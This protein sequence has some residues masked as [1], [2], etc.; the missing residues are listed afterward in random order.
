MDIKLLMQDF[1]NRLSLPY[2]KKSFQGGGM[3]TSELSLSGLAE[4]LVENGLIDCQSAQKALAESEADQNSFVA[5]VVEKKLLQAHDIA[6][7]AYQDYGLPLLDLS[8]YD[9]E[10]IPL[11]LV[12]EKL[13]TKHHAL[14]LFRRNHHL[15]VAIS[16]PNNVL[17]LTEIKF[18]TGLQTKAVLVE[19]DKLEKFIENVL[20]AQAGAALGDLSDSSLDNLDISSDDDDN[21]EESS[22]GDDAPIVRFVH[23]ILLDAI[24]KGASDIHFEPYEKI[25][26]VRYRID[27]VLHENAT[28]PVKLANRIVSRLKVMSRLDISERRIPQ[29]GRFK[30][31]LSHKRAIDFRVSTCP[32]VNGEKVV[33]RILDPS[34]AKIGIDGLGF[35][36]DQKATFLEA[37]EQPQGMIL[38]TGPTGSGKTVTLYTA[39][40]LLNTREKNISTAEDPVEIHVPGINQVNINSKTGLDFSS[41]LRSFLRQDPDII[42]VGEMRDLETAEIGVKAA[43]TGHLVL[44]TLHTN[45]APETLTRLANMGIP[46]YNIATSVHLIIAQRLSRRLCEHCKI[47]VAVPEASLVSLGFKESELNDIQIFGPVGCDQCANGYKG[48]IGLYEVLP[49][50]KKIGEIIMNKGSSLDISKQAAIEGVTTIRDAGL[51]KLKEGTI[52]IEELN[53]VTT[54]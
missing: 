18:Q 11:E 5:H 31:R 26:R 17:A 47:K 41:A 28:P 2:R 42:M 51:K 33:M 30:M 43:Q 15:F 40:N 1:E 35:N 10:L 27:G 16:D 4:R 53:R 37:I 32:T 20:S 50:S 49:I 38:V 39:L 29:D 9:K 36:P 3:Q 54:D 45:S 19:E 34:S 24:N 21:T 8:Q 13:I 12:N 52:S 44:S 7:I 14:P 25:F 46:A 48:R 6:H 23:K 22:D